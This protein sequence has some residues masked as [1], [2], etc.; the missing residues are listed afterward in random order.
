MFFSPYSI[1]AA[2]AMTYAGARGETQRQM[3]RVLHFTLPGERLHAAFA[4][5]GKKMKVTADELSIANALW[6]QKDYKFLDEFLDT[7]RKYYGAG[8]KEVDFAGDS[9]GARQE[10]NAWVEKE[11]K[12]KIKDLIGKGVLD[13]LT[14]LV[15]TNA[16][17]FKADWDIQFDKENTRQEPFAVTRLKEV[18]AEMMNQK[19]R[20]NYARNDDVQL[21][22]LA[23]KDENLSMI[24][25]LPNKRFGLEEVE[26]QF[27]L[28][29]VTEWMGQM[30]KREVV[31]Y[32]PKFKMTTGFE[33]SDYLCKMGMPDAFSARWADFSGM[34]RARELFISKVIHQAFVAVDEQGT[35]AA[36][37]TAVVMKLRAAPSKPEVFRADHPFMFIIRDNKTRS[38]L[39]VGRVGDPTRNA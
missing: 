14:R 19:G 22:E 20:F 10:I 3:S 36:A 25:V 9:E 11:T 8:L 12:D 38:I 34:T 4:E 1:S 33:L 35:E 15:L 30:R 6:G 16:I 2:L 28:E 32:M 18:Q 5:S 7:N 29:T 24:V 21:L 31:V 26:K 27:N 17:Y 39:F 13:G 23:Y 37:A